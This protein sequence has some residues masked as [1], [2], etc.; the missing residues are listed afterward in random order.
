[1]S[2]EVRRD[3]MREYRKGNEDYKLKTQINTQKYYQEN[4]EEIIIVNKKWARDNPEKVRKN[5][6]R[7]A[8]NNRDKINKWVRKWREDNPEMTLVNSAKRYKDK[9]ALI[10]VL[11][12]NFLQFGSTCCENCHTAIWDKYEFDHIVP[13]A[14]GGGGDYDNLQILCK[15]CNMEKFT[16]AIDFRR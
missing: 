8:R 11:N 4:R 14:L 16:N 15:P 3:Y 7:W 2:K 10:Q 12:V 6:N 1:M 13:I 9:D 5:R